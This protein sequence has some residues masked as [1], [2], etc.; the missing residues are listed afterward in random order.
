MHQATQSSIEVMLPLACVSRRAA[1][2]ACVFCSLRP[3]E[4]AAAEDKT[5]QRCDGAKARRLVLP[6]AAWRTAVG[7]QSSTRTA[8]LH[9]STGP[10]A[11]SGDP[12]GIWQ[13]KSRGPAPEASAPAS[14]FGVGTP[15]DHIQTI[16]RPQPT[17]PPRPRATNLRRRVMNQTAKLSVVLVPHNNRPRSPDTRVLDPLR[18][19]TRKL[20]PVVARL[21]AQ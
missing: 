14:A 18:N 6:S 3:V 9:R 17:L 16:G 13:R 19:K 1:D 20:F 11:V 2:G 7:R 12:F 8:V 15:R 10:A 5:R 21:W 4:A